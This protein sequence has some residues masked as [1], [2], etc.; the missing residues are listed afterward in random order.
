MRTDKVNKIYGA[1]GI[2]N[3]NTTKITPIKHLDVC[4]TRI[5]HFIALA[6]YFERYRVLY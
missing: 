4:L 3:M 1:E 6:G 5:T 2:L